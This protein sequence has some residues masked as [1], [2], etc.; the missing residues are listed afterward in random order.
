MASMTSSAVVPASRVAGFA[1]RRTTNARVVRRGAVAQ[2]AR[3]EYPQENQRARCHSFFRHAL[4]PDA[5]Q[6]RPTA[7][8]FVAGR[9]LMRP[10][11]TP[12]LYLEPP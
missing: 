6:I 10:H 3:G 4:G 2:A 1:P 11:G 12:L 5:S 8:F 9:G 7:R